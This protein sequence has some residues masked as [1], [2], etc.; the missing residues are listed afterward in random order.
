MLDPLVV[1]RADGGGRVRA[2]GQPV[3]GA[4]RV[5]KVLLGGRRW[6]PGNAAARLI[7]LNGGTGAVLTLDGAVLALVGVTVAEGRITEI[8]LVANPEKLGE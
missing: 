8:D 3:V 2:A 7:A 1:L 6:Y 5:A 4:E